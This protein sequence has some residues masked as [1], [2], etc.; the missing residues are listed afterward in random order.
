M[1]NGAAA[2]GGVAEATDAVATTAAASSAATEDSSVDCLDETETAAP[3][4]TAVSSPPQ[5]TKTAAGATEAVSAILTSVAAAQTTEAAAGEN[6]QAFTGTLGGTAPP[7]I[8]SNGD[9]PFSVN[10]NTFTGSGAALGRSCDI[11]HNAC[12]NAA[13]SGQLAGGVAQCEQQSADCKAANDLKK[14]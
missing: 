13:N 1:V 5:A 12:A 10:G 4:E 2:A 3:V 9:R 14:L 11:Q 6:I 8:S 7:V